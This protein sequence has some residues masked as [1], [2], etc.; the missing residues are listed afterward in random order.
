AGAG[1]GVEAARAARGRLAAYPGG[2]EVGWARAALVQAL[3]D[4]DDYPA[5]RD[6]ARKLEQADKNSPLIVPVRLLMSRWATEKARAD[7]AR[8]INDDL[9]ARN[10]DAPT[11]AYVLLLSAETSRLAGQ[12]AEARDRFELARRA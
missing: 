2:R 11:R 9:L 3:L 10:L 4:P 12:V 1:E 7:Q 5:A 6:E 8:E